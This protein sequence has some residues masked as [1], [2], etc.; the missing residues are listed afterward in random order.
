MSK[1]REKI[2]PSTFERIPKKG[3]SISYHK[4]K[5]KCVECGK[6]FVTNHLLQLKCD[7]CRGVK[8]D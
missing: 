3:N 8:D 5:A 1:H 4:K 6:M 2:L 7:V